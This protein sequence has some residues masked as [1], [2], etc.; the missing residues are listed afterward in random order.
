MFARDV[1]H[2]A[3]RKGIQ[4]AK[5]PYKIK[6]HYNTKWVKDGF[7]VSQEYTQPSI[8]WRVPAF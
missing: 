6:K 2:Q 7:K 4:S 8:L 3:V 1:A 5:Y